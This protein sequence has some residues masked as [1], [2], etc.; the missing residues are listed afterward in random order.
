[1]LTT[2]KIELLINQLFKLKNMYPDDAK[3]YDR[4]IRVLRE[5]YTAYCN[6]QLTAQGKTQIE[7]PHN[8]YQDA[9]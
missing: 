1:M 2:F 3:F 4:K 5:R 6:Y 8:D 7:Q 9:T